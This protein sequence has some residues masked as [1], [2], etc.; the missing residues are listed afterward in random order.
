MST[1][2]NSLDFAALRQDFPIFQ[3][4]ERSKPII[5]LDSAASAQKPR[6]V[7]NAMSDFYLQDYASIHRGIYELSERATK[8]YEHAREAVKK[9][10]HAEHDDEIIFVSN[11]TAGINFV[12]QS[13]GRSQWKAGD[14]VILSTMEHHSNIVPWYL[15][16]EQ[17]GIEIKVIP[18]TDTGELDME[19]YQTLFSPRTKMVSVTHASNVLGTINPVK[20][21]CAIAHAHRVPVLIDGAQ[22]VPHMS[23]DVQEIDCDF[24]V[25]SAHKLYGPTGLGVLYAKKA[26]LDAMPPYQGGGGMIETVTFSKVTF[27]KTPQ[28]FEAGTPHIA[29]VIGLEAAIHYLQS[30]GMQAVFAHEQ[31]LLDYAK[32]KLLSIPELRIIGTA[33]VKVGVISFVLDSI[34]P[35]DISTVL[36]HEGIAVRAGHHCAMPLM[37][38]FQVPATVRVSFGIYNNEKDI[39]ALIEAILLAKRLFS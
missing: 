27:A 37:E 5:Y 39:D 7:V 19:A 12:S 36:D 10:I 8:S 18:V 14:E 9:F 1:K 24:Y 2:I 29:G 33:Q 15:L 16:K 11:T 31:T 22:A 3:E 34:H 13:F 23:V 17:I 35:H 25:F 4:K 38:R 32:L 6:Q 28:K 26:H 20:K 30:I 21:I